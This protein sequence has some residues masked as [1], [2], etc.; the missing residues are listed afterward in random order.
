MKK[1]K[2]LLC[3]LSALLLLFMVPAYPVHA[4]EEEAVQEDKTGAPFFMWRQM[5]SL[6]TAFRSKRPAW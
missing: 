4:E 6:W 3:F 5:M 2:R 1:Y